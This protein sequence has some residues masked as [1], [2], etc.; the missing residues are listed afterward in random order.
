M[1]RSSSIVDPPVFLFAV[2]V[3]QHLWQEDELLL[4][5]VLEG[6]QIRGGGN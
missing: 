4:P 3:V 6:E 2:L 1:T 5:D